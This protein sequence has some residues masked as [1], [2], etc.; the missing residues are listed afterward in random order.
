MFHTASTN[1][2]HAEELL[3]EVEDFEE[4][5]LNE[6]SVTLAGAIIRRAV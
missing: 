5:S 3:E 1:F 6:V 4:E 2:V